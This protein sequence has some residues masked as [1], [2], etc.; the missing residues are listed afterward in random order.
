VAPFDDF[1]RLCRTAISEGVTPGLVALVAAGGR[2]LLQEAFGF[3]QIGPGAELPVTLETVYDLSS[4][5]KALVTSVLAM[6]AVASG[7]LRL[8]DPAPG[9]AASD[10][11]VRLLL[12]HASGLPA[13]RRYFDDLGTDLARPASSP[14]QRAR[15]VAMAAAEE[16]VYPPGTRSIYSDVGFILL[17]DLLERLLGARLDVLAGEG[18]LGPLG[19][20]ALGFL[21]TSGPSPTAFGGRPV[22]PTQLCPA[23]GR[24]MVGEV[25]DLNAHV[26]GGV[27]GHAGL[28]GTAAAVGAVAHALCAAWRDAAPCGAHPIVPGPVLRAFWTPAGIPGSSWRLGWDGPAPAGSIAGDLISRAAV[29]HLGFTGCSLWIDPAR[30]TFVLVLSNRVYPTARD[31]PR[32]RALRR[33]LNDAALTDAGY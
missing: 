27:A 30:E 11:S 25:D 17:G 12:A 20:D 28:F 32:F 4:L 10:A 15:V 7:R 1:R 5:T 23:R 18:I 26:M 29:G 13:H 19:I 22:A 31:D 16:L 9:R 6:Q 33:A 3:R 21:G 2:T 8:E 24:L 14:E